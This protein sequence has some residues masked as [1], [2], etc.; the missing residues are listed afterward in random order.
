MKIN[1]AIIASIFLVTPI[2]ALLERVRVNPVQPNLNDFE[3]VA[4][5]LYSAAYRSNYIATGIL[6][7][8]QIETSYK[9]TLI[10]DTFIRDEA[11]T[12]VFAGE[13][14]LNVIKQCVFI[15]ESAYES[16]IPFLDIDLQTRISKA[17]AK[18]LTGFEY[19]F[20]FYR[21]S[22]YENGEKIDALTNDTEII[23]APCAM[24]I[25]NRDDDE[26]LILRGQAT[27]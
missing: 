21:V 18:T 5:T 25:R 2:E 22:E 26:V 4:K 14:L 9:L 7:M 1:S 11:E 15:R 16:I 6:E 27:D 23:M 8:N 17:F 3:V 20:D 13:S 12:N 10:T 19:N 24:A